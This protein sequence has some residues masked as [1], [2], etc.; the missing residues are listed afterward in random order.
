[1]GTFRDAWLEFLGFFWIKSL[2]QIKSGPPECLLIFP[3][4]V[5]NSEFLMLQSLS[6]C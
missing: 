4:K 5:D 1:M 6:P 2:N 3:N